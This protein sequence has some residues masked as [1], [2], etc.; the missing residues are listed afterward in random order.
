MK[1]FNKF[2]VDILNIFLIAS[3]INGISIIE[4]GEGKR[5]E[6]KREEMKKKRKSQK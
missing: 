4:K 6:I 5:K 2:N 3:V 1:I